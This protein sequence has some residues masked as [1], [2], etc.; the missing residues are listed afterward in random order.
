MRI[1]TITV[2]TGLTVPHPGLQ[3][4]SLRIYLE[5]EVELSHDDDAS[6][7]IARV[8][9]DL[10][11]QAARRLDVM[12]EAERN[13]PA[14]HWQPQQPLQERQPEEVGWGH[15]MSPFAEDE[16][17]SE[18]SLQPEGFHIATDG[19]TRVVTAHKL[20]AKHEQPAAA[21]VAG[22][23]VQIPEPAPSLPSHTYR[24]KEFK[25]A[26]TGPAAAMRAALNDLGTCESLDVF[27]QLRPEAVK[28]YHWFNSI[29]HPAKADDLD[30]ALVDVEARLVDVAES[31]SAAQEEDSILATIKAE[32]EA[33][34][35]AHAKLEAPTTPPIRLVQGNGGDQ[36]KSLRQLCRE[37]ANVIGQ[38]AVQAI[39]QRN[40]ATML[41]DLTPAGEI[42]VRADIE[43]QLKLA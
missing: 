13:A 23:D 10:M 17:T 33:Q 5:A 21:T 40:G 36:P 38:P 7:V 32:Q 34:D 30:A 9:G 31:V 43:V 18:E 14:G 41:K 2:G 12:A 20:G 42:A 28:L 26:K 24:G 16:P 37:A 15:E 35:E 25:P 39:L 11:D 8:H 22:G 4:A 27:E 3:Y 29:C 6:V 19:S 1:T